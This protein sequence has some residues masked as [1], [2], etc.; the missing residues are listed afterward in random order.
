MDE[1]DL[2]EVLLRAEERFGL[3]LPD[4]DIGLSSTVSNIV[5]L[6]VG[7][8]REQEAPLALPQVIKAARE[9]APEVG[10]AESVL[11]GADQ[12]PSIAEFKD[13]RDMLHLDQL[14][15]SDP[16]VVSRPT[17]SGADP[18]EWLGS[19]ELWAPSTAGSCASSLQPQNSSPEGDTMVQIA[20]AINC[21]SGAAPQ[22]DGRGTGWVKRHR[23]NICLGGGASPSL[24]GACRLADIDLFRCNF[25]GKAPFLL[26]P[27]L[28]LR[29]KLKNAILRRTPRRENTLFG[30]VP[31]LQLP[32]LAD[33]RGDIAGNAVGPPRISSN[34]SDRP[35]LQGAVAP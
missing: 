14:K 13:A 23:G 29:R 8:L 10:E 6:I 34:A 15:P 7:R 3:V 28:I 11:I 5:D 33:A 1:V 20:G 32:T 12:A 26:L 4:N 22:V 24:L 27:G 17:I 21:T 25:K 35:S 30:D 16:C 9:N 2:I 19:P 18:G 31:S